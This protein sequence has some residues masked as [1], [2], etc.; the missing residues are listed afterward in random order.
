[1]ASGPAFIS[2]SCVSIWQGILGS[3]LISSDHGALGCSLENM[4]EQAVLLLLKHLNFPYTS[5]DALNAHTEIHS[6]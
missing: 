1:M 2:W 3:D 4:S 6:I 5:E